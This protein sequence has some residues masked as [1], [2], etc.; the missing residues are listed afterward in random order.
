MTRAKICGITTPEEARL[1]ERLGAHAIGILVGRRH[2]SA[3]FVDAEAAREICLALPPYVVSVLVTHVEQP[4]ELVALAL[5]IPCG[6]IQ[7]HSDVDAAVLADLRSRLPARKVIGK[8][9]VEDE[10]AIARAHE[11]EGAVDAILLDSRD[12][13]SD[14]VG[15]TGLVHDWSISARIVSE[16]RVP[17]ILAG[18]LNPDNLARAISLVRPWAVDTHTGVETADGRK[19]EDKMRAF[20]QTA[21]AG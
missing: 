16:C 13:A 2:Q 14:R 5:A 19:S 20:I 1:A 18:G 7:V 11:I 17:V 6:A 3:D 15:G 8:V 9:S 4:D 12:R 21:L 10:S